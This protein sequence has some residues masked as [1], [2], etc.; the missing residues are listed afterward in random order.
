MVPSRRGLLEVQLP[1]LSPGHSLE[2]QQGKEPGGLSAVPL[3][4]V[5][6]LF[7]LGARDVHFSTMSKTPSFSWHPG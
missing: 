1:F 3:P 2:V 4:Q 6:L 7:A 5:F